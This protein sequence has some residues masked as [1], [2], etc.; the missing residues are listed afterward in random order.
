VIEARIDLLNLNNAS[1]SAGFG[2]VR[3]E[4][5]KGKGCGRHI[6][7]VDDD[8]SLNH[9]V[10]LTLRRAGYKVDS[11][12]NGESGWNAIS[13]NGFDLLITD[14]AMPKLNGLAL[15]RR[16][17]DNSVDLPAILMSA[18]MPRNVAEIIDLV[19]PGGALH[20]PFETKELIF[21]VETVLDGKQSPL[22]DISVEFAK[23]QKDS[24]GKELGDYP[25]VKNSTLTEIARKLLAHEAIS[26][27]TQDRPTV[28]RVCDKMRESILN[29]AGETGLQSIMAHALLN[30]KAEVEW[31][32]PVNISPR[33][34]FEGLSV[35]EA[36]L[37]AGEIFRGETVIVS[38]I[39]GLLFVF[40]GKSMT[41]MLLQEV[42]ME[43]LFA[44]DRPSGQTLDGC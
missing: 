32:A 5:K 13:K 6:L 28:F 24:G 23:K 40:L 36:K 20:K 7:V 19:S 22:T 15:L 14:Y 41:S 12:E 35:A 27:G 26:K 44:A 42:W 18:D 21:T 16:L 37:P 10:A 8:V 25:D 29:L 17:R 30:A 38:Q 33:G 31:L 4:K 43:T 3:T 11:A 2:A 1:D 9:M 34:F 39:L